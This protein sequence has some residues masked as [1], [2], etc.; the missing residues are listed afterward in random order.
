M[1]ELTAAVLALALCGGVSPAIAQVG[2]LDGARL[3][4]LTLKLSLSDLQRQKVEALLARY[5]AHSV[6]VR[7]GLIGVQESIR[8]ANLGRLGDAAIL[9][10]SSEAG[11]LSAA[12]T[13]SLLKT[14][15]DFYALL[16]AKQKREYNKMRSEALAQQATLPNK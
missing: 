10:M 14:Q 2:G 3:E 6:G 12:H 15:R 11:R 8:S 7:E 4:E 1:K 16:S 5:A 13:E 9:R